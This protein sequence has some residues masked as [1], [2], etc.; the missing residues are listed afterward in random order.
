MAD[1]LD[2]LGQSATASADVRPAL[3]LEVPRTMTI[4]E[5]A[6]D[7]TERAGFVRNLSA[8]VTDDAAETH[9]SSFR[10]QLDTRTARLVKSDPVDL[11]DELADLGFAWRDIARMVGVSVPALRRWR[12]GERPT[13]E[14]RRAIGQLLA[15]VQII[16]SEVF[17]PASWMEVPLSRDAPITAIDLYTAGQL[18]L[19]FDLATGNRPPDAALDI[20][21]PGWRERYRSDWE[22]ATAEDGQP[23]IRPKSGP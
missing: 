2:S 17:E 6:R 23:F 3:S 7:L 5:R 16:T 20:V 10:L 22:V 19:I 11:L 14:N 8:V 15:F 21:R 13:G 18:D 1:V 9:H 12:R 4:E